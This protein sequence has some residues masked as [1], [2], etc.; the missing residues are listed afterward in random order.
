MTHRNTAGRAAIRPRTAAALLPVAAAAAVFAHDEDW[1]KLADR[2]PPVEGP[3]VTASDPA[4]LTPSGSQFDA[5]NAALLAWMPLSA[6]PG[7]QATGNDCWGYLSPS[8]R[9]YAIMGLEKG[10]AFVE[11]TQPT[12]PQLV[13]YIP[14]AT[15]LWHDVKV[16][17]EYAYAVSEGGLG[18]QVI[19]LSLI[20]SG[21]VTLI[22][23]KTQA[24][25]STTHNIAANTDSGYLYLTGANIQNG[26]LVA[27]STDD[28]TDPTI[29]GAWNDRY[30]HDA[31][32][33]TYTDGPYAGREIAFCFNGGFGVEIIDVTDKG[34]MVKIGGSSY[35]GVAFTHQGWISE[36]KQLLYVNDELDEGNTVSVT[37]TRV[38]DIS[39]LSSPTLLGTFSTGKPAVDHNLYVHE[40]LVYQAN[41]RSGLRVFDAT[42][43]PASPPEVA[44]FDTYPDN[45]NPSFNGAWSVYPY[46]PSGTIIVSD[47]ERGLFLLDVNP[48]I[49]TFDFPQGLPDTIEPGTPNPVMALVGELN[50]TLDDDSVELHAT[51]DG[52]PVQTTAMTPLGDGLYT[53][54]LPPAFCD[55]DVAFWFSA[56]NTDGES[57][58]SPSGGD[59]HTTTV[60]SESILAVDDAFESSSGWTAGLPGDT[61]DTGQWTR[62]DPIGTDAQPEDDH[63][64]GAPNTDCYFTGQGSF[65]GDLGE[66]DVDGGFTTLLS[67][68]FDLADAE[69]AIIS[70]WRWYSNNTGNA[71]G[72]DVFVIDVS[73]DGGAS[74]TNVET[75]GPAGPG[76]SGG[77]IAHEFNLAEFV[78]PT[79]QVRMRFIAEDDP[80]DGE[81]SLVEAAIDDFT[82]TTLA[83][84]DPSCIA[85]FN[86]DGSLSILDF[87]AF[88]GAF[89]TGD[90]AADVNGDDILNILDF[91]AFQAE[92][93]E[94]C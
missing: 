16:I 39:D 33:V 36:D 64:Q 25:H 2:E 12:N 10:T 48:E 63:T 6:F 66:N 67:P 73:N 26:G 52:G 74:W 20:D 60:A 5:E 38:F 34:N 30:V 21:L 45:D 18:I 4:G 92:F 40:G 90:L 51:L 46:L 31:Q 68:T 79:A 84:D 44:W 53:G 81:G 91:I 8:G 22:K 15:S 70:Y 78:E 54:D 69:D 85:D 42:T 9:E 23:N 19:D 94:G 80:S 14:G 32:V 50:T 61:A 77:W 75:I 29:A 65:G 87:I 3:I 88:Q 55:Q 57:F 13:E 27:V 72:T 17:G 11:V 82:V 58:S 93:A 56:Q 62:A 43:S 28:P 24:G 71:P 41:Y 7:G 59:A 1:R 86:A 47:I 76:T 49:L 35:P 89:A 37:T 83:C